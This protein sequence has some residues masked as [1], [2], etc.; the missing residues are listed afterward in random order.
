ML[1]FSHVDGATDSPSETVQF[2]LLA[3]DKY[4]SIQVW[5]PG[6]FYFWSANWDLWWAEVLHEELLLLCVTNY[7]DIQKQ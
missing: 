6:S 5:S 2:S 1:F 4:Q 3:I 7:A